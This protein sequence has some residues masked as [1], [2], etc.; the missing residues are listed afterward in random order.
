MQFA[1]KLE[2]LRIEQCDSLTSLSGV[3]QCAGLERLELVNDDGLYDI[4]AIKSLENLKQLFI[5][6]RKLPEESELPPL[7]DAGCLTELRQ[8]EQL[9]LSVPHWKNLKGIESLNR[10]TDLTLAQA[11]DLEDL[12][13]IATLPRLKV[14]KLIGASSLKQLVIPESTELD[15]VFVSGAAS[16]ESIVLAGDQSQITS[17]SVLNCPNLKD[18]DELDRCPNLRRVRI[19]KVK[20]LVDTQAETA[21]KDRGVIFEYVEDH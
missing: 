20:H 6:Q 3:E 8:L 1:P 9:H 14:L 10:L 5:S 13:A 2:R 15:Q 19:S 18:I 4:S 21:F 17:L 11:H 12:S 16:L 7:D